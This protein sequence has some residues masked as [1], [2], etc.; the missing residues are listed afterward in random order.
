M[1]RKLG[2]QHIALHV[3]GTA[4][5]SKELNPPSDKHTPPTCIA[6]SRSVPLCS[7]LPGMG[8]TWGADSEKDTCT[9]GWHASYVANLHSCVSVDISL[10]A[11]G[12]VDH[13]QGL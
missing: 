9:G 3:K 8:C 6:S 10:Q 4:I 1:F 2:Q 11:A 5:H 12:D 7:T 13:H